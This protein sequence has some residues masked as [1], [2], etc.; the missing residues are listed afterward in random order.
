[1][2]EKPDEIVVTPGGPR[3][4]KQVH[5][6]EPGQ[7]VHMDESGTVRVVMPLEPRESAKD[8]AQDL[9]LTPG[10]FRSRSLVQQV[11]EGHAVHMTDG[12]ARL[13]NLSTGALI[14]LPKITAEEKVAPALGSGWIAY[15]YWNNG[16]GNSLSSFRTTWQVPP[17]PASK[18]NQIIFLFNGIQ[19]YGNNF[20]ILQPVLQWGV[21]AAGGGQYWAVASWYV[22][23]GG[24]AFHTNLVKVNPGDTLIGVMTLSGHTGSSF[25]Y[26]SQFQ[27]IAGTTLPVNNIAELLWCNETLEAYTVNACSEYPGIDHTA[28]RSISIQTGNVTP[29]LNWTP[30]NKVTDCGQSAKV[31]S[32]SATNGE[33][34]IYYRPALVSPRVPLK[35]QVEVVSRSKDKLDVF[36]TDNAGVTRTAAWEPTFT[37]WWHGWWEL[38][39]G[40]AKPGAPIHGVSRSTD[41][42]DVFVI[43]TD[44]NVYTAAWEPANTDWWHGWWKLRNGIGAAGGHV[45]VVSRAPDKLDVFVVGTDRRVWTAAWQPSF[46]DWWHGWWPIGNIKVPPGSPI[47]AVSRSTDKLDIFVTDEN[48][49][50]QTAAWE[51]S[52][53]DGWHGWW[54]IQGGRAAPGAAVTA[55][56]RSTDKLDVFVVGNDGRVWTAAWQPNFGSWHGWWPIGN[57]HVPAGAPIHCVSRSADKLD[58]FATDNG[59]VIRTAAWEPAFT[60]GWHGWWELNGGRAAP[61][62][63]VTAVSRSKDKLDVFVVSNDQRVWT[64]AWEPTFTDWWHGWWPMGQ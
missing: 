13:M 62:S 49:I 28:F 24:Q 61:G 58:I 15:A 16:T 48:G 45:T 21:S 7:T 47:H 5:S 11:T 19:N 29:A 50:V 37:D 52:F 51:P 64:A 33:V 35:S 41:K 32:N 25:N 22:T 27:G 31:V 3:P 6:V 14:D 54:Q 26:S 10:G 12:R 63:P 55:V 1:M 9:V 42:L 18:S 57:I 44:T 4:K 23:S 2:P 20:G 46:T 34:D 40:R 30:V 59:G 8:V 60:D 43:G 38:N 17:E 39:G 36:V 53:T 56:S